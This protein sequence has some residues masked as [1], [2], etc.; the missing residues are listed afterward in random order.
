MTTTHFDAH[1][2]VLEAATAR[3][4]QRRE[5]T[6]ACKRSRTPFT[7]TVHAHKG[8]GT[9]TQEHALA[10]AGARMQARAGAGERTEATEAG[11]H[12]LPSVKKCD[13][14]LRA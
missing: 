6:G 1:A 12:S 4:A 3:L 5:R 14:A 10:N 7:Q 8:A 2:H 11:L 9:L 13:A